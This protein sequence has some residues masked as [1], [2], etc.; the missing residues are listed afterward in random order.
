MVVLKF[1]EYP[2]MI[3]PSGWNYG[4]SCLHLFANCY[5][6]W[7]NWFYLIDAKECL[8]SQTLIVIISGPFNQKNKGAVKS[9]L[10]AAQ[11]F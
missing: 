10:T 3:F 11:N 1:F 9:K 5:F 4:S 7:Q 8:P 2:C 6:Q